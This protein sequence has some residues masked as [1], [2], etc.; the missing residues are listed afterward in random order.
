MFYFDCQRCI[1]TENRGCRDCEFCTLGT[2]SDPEAV[3]EGGTGGLCGPCTNGTF[4]TDANFQWA[5]VGAVL[6]TL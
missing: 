2:R 5:S 1:L 4:P 6:C 3:A